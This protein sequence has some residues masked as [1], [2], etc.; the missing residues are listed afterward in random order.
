MVY[1][2]NQ[3]SVRF[4]DRV[5][6]RDVSC[7]LGEG[8]WISVVGP[9][10]AGKSTFAHALKGLL[11]LCEGEYF[12]NQSPAPKDA[13]GHCSVITDIGFV[14]QYPEHQIFESTVYK[15]LAFAPRMQGWS[16]VRIEEAI[17]QILPL[18]GMGRELLPWVP[19]QLSGGQKRRVALASVLLMNPRLLILDEPTAGLDPA[20]RF[21]LLRML[22]AW[23]KAENRTIVFISHQMEDVAEFSDEVM[24]FHQG[25]LLGYEDTHTLFFERSDLLEQAGLPLPEAVQLMRLVEEL[26]GR[27]IEVSSCREK[28]IL[29]AVLPFWE[30]RGQ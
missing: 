10:G 29:D 28:D 12:I 24:V 26:S 11:P 16:S 9:S 21:A 19:L 5:V 14:F 4:A 7:T 22:Q 3:A 18:V 23:Q 6:L 13:K 8:K 15:E 25:Q 17:E 1:A 30:V 27:S 20:G 2:L